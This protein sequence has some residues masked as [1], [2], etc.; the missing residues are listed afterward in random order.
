MHRSELILPALFNPKPP[1][2]SAQV[3]VYIKVTKYE[4]KHFL[5]IVILYCQKWHSKSHLKLL[6]KLTIT[7]QIFRLWFLKGGGK[8]SSSPSFFVILGILQREK[9]ISTEKFS[10]FLLRA[11]VS[12]VLFL[13]SPDAICFEN[14]CIK[15]NV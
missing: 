10:N 9:K 13:C 14:K 15:I 1:F 4:I 7:M 3:I 6:A 12:S 8:Q 11:I 5:S 2:I